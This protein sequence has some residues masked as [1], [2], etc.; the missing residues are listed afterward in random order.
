MIGESQ[1]Q[2]LRRPPLVYQLLYACR[3]VCTAVR[4][5]W[6][7]V[8]FIVRGVHLL[9]AFGRGVACWIF[10]L[11][12]ALLALAILANVTFGL[13]RTLLHPWFVS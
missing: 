6:L 8:L 7:P 12:L 5:T 9:E 13:V 11:W 1:T 10:R 2:P 4:V 3:L